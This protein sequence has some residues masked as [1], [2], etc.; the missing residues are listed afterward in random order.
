[1]TGPP[2]T[3]L[4]FE[5]A[6]VMIFARAD[7]QSFVDVRAGDLHRQTG[8]YPGNHRMPVCCDVMRKAMQ[9]GDQV[10]REP[11]KGNGASLTI[12]YLLPRA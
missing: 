10:L 1:M 9:P 2:P 4:D 7:D 3:G 12:R 8:G 11:P 5:H 6:L